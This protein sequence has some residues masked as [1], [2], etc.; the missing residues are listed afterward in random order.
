MGSRHP[1]STNVP[2]SPRL[3]D[4]P[5][6]PFDVEYRGFPLPEWFNTTDT[7]LVQNARPDTSSVVFGV[8]DN[9]V[10]IRHMEIAQR[11]NEFLGLQFGQ[12]P[13]PVRDFRS[14]VPSTNADVIGEPLRVREA[15]TRPIIPAANVPN[16]LHRGMNGLPNE[17]TNTLTNGGRNRVSSGETT[18]SSNLEANR[19]SNGDTNR[20]LN[21]ETN[22]VLNG[23]T[24]RVPNDLHRWNNGFSNGSH[25][26]TNHLPNRRR[27]ITN[28]VRHRPPRVFNDPE[29]EEYVSQMPEHYQE[30]VRAVYQRPPS[31]SSS[32]RSEGSE[33]EHSI[34]I[35]M[36]TAKIEYFDEPF[37]EDLLSG[38]EGQLPR[39]STEPDSVHIENVERQQD[40]YEQFRGRLRARGELPA[41]SANSAQ[42]DDWSEDHDKALGLSSS[43]KSPSMNSTKGIMGPSRSPSATFTNANIPMWQIFQGFG[44]KH[45]LDDAPFTLWD[46]DMHD[47][48]EPTGVER[49]WIIAQYQA[50]NVHCVWPFIFIETDHIPTNAP[51]T[52]G[53]AY[54]VF[55][56]TVDI[57]VEDEFNVIPGPPNP[58]GSVVS[59]HKNSMTPLTESPLTKWDWPS[60][61]QLE[62]VLHELRQHCGVKSITF[63]LGGKFFVE[64][65]TDNGR[66]YPNRSLPIRVADIGMNYHHCP[67]SVWKFLDIQLSGKRSPEEDIELGERLY[68]FCDERKLRVMGPGFPIQMFNFSNLVVRTDDCW[69][70]TAGVKIK[71]VT[72]GKERITI[73]VPADVK[74]EHVT[75]GKKS[76]EVHLPRSLDISAQGWRV[77][78]VGESYAEQEIGLVQ[79]EFDEG[80]EFRNSAPVGAHIPSKLLTWPNI[81][82]GRPFVVGGLNHGC[83]HVFARGLHLNIDSTIP[84]ETRIKIGPEEMAKVKWIFQV[85]GPMSEAMTEAACGA[86]IVEDDAGFAGVAGFYECGVKG[87]VVASGLDQIVRDGWVVCE[88]PEVGGR[89]DYGSIEVGYDGHDDRANSGSGSTG[90]PVGDKSVRNIH[91]APD[92]GIGVAGPSDKEREK[93]P[94]RDH[95]WWKLKGG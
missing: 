71:H 48:R 74:I 55:R 36:F 21:G 61:E 26:A 37:E 40:Q 7:T 87:W 47:F 46:G 88:D 94:S 12:M 76:V 31:S 5:Y 91:Y 59:Y 15:P 67:L 72:D 42:V 68:R 6:A 78:T 63:L 39:L 57:F 92:P 49:E 34:D 32:E 9:P 16:G 89:V 60:V 58:A 83:Q 54:A 41:Q 17:E 14:N 35:F 13:N 52:V 75:S 51:L 29:F 10:W 82:A 93:K 70:S 22:R 79:P 43:E 18:R 25:H 30:M 38:L 27:R 86:A 53:C 8:V 20:V 77:G 64:L 1:P 44:S 66:E 28:C 11:R 90:D 85:L 24:I 95:A 65:D 4:P 33:D 81:V 73:H 2:S 50:K 62:A 84:E 80:G 23:E 56:K 69:T 45:C 19:L 3:Q